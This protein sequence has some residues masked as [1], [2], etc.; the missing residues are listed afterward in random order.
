MIVIPVFGGGDM[1]FDQLWS[2]FMSANTPAGV[3]LLEQARK[4]AA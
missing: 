2:I 1:R 3:P 4:Y